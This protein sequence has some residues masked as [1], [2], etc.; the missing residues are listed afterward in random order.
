MRDQKK[1]HLILITYV[2]ILGVACSSDRPDLARSSCR[3]TSE[4]LKKRI[5][6]EL[7]QISSLI[8]LPT[9]SPELYGCVIIFSRIS[10]ELPGEVTGEFISSS[11]A[12]EVAF[13]LPDREGRT[14]LTVPSPPIFQSEGTK[15]LVKL[16][17]VFG[18]GNPEVL[19]EEHDPM[20]LDR[21]LSMRVYLYAE[22]VP[23]PKEIFAEP[24]VSSTSGDAQS[25]SWRI[26]EFENSVAIFLTG[27][28][29]RLHIWNDSIQRFEYDLSASQRFVQSGNASVSPLKRISKEDVS[30]PSISPPRTSERPMS[31]VPL[32]TP[33]PAPMRAEP[34]TPK[35]KDSDYTFEEDTKRETGSEE[36]QSDRAQP[37]E[38]IDEDKS[39]SS[40]D[41][42]TTVKEFLEGI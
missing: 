11:L 25:V 31:L 2:L 18:G 33:D 14:I 17:E 34:S 15:L 1:L 30:K 27:R 41:K 3:S 37:E 23:K 7:D 5:G 29:T 9:S 35:S 36:G 26:G 6:P 32:A 42:V 16:Q 28:K 4:T 12:Q 21:V 38:G 20:E 40:E 24:L 10:E 39:K 22:D 19:I 13:G 8:P